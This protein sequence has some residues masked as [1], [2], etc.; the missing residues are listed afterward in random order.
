MMGWTRTGWALVPE[1]YMSKAACKNDARLFPTTHDILADLGFVR[2]PNCDGGPYKVERRGETDP[3]LEDGVARKAT[4]ERL[5]AIMFCLRGLRPRL[6]WFRL[7]WGWVLHVR[8]WA[9]PTSGQLDRLPW[10]VGGLRPTSSSFR[11]ACGRIQ[12]MPPRYR[13]V[14]ERNR[15]SSTED[16]LHSTKFGQALTNF[17]WCRA[18]LGRFRPKLAEI[19]QIGPGSVKTRQVAVR[20]GTHFGAFRPNLGRFREKAPYRGARAKSH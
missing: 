4:V 1:R 14:S 20:L 2:E 18:T 11:H 6:R 13:L 17:S 9:R 16:V 12:P 15:P 10:E 7:Y 19:V 8:G 3:K 5:L